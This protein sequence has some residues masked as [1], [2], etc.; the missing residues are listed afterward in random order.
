MKLKGGDTAMKKLLV[1]SVLLMTLVIMTFA[2]AQSSCSSAEPKM[3]MIRATGMGGECEGM[4]AGKCSGDEC[5]GMCQEMGGCEEKFFLCCAKELELTDEQVMK[6]KN[7]QF[8]Q[9]KNCIRSNADLKILELEL[10]NLLLQNEPDRAAIDKKITAMGELKTKMK[11]NEIYS[12]L[13][14]KMVLTKEQLEKYKNASGG[15]CGMGMMKVIETKTCTKEGTCPG[16]CSE[17][18]KKCEE[19]SK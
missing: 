11:R 7:I 17:E 13:D 8:E 9:Q 16:S 3:M 15:S 6:L 14:A 19:R 4:Q 18:N 12:R 10:G 2:Y 1:P 5:A